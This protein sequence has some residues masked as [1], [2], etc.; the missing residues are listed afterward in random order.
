MIEE[1]ERMAIRYA[2]DAILV[3]DKGQGTAYLQA[4]GL[5]DAQRR[6]APAPLIPI[7]PGTQSKEFRFDEVCPLIEQGEVFLPSGADWLD[8]FIVEVGQFP[9]GAHDDQVDALSQYLRYAKN[10]RTRFG[11]RKITSMG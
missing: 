11:T 7:N 4:R 3:E 8:A 1:I 6:L 2:V 5:T 9:A 10:T